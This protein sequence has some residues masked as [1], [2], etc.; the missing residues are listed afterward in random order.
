MSVATQRPFIEVF[1]RKDTNLEKIARRAVRQPD[2]IPEI[3]D[4]LSHDKTP[5]KYGCAKV[6]RIIAETRPDLLY[7]HFTTFARLLNHD[8]NIMKWE[9]IF[10]ISC[11]SVVD[12][13]NR[14]NRILKKYLKPITGP[15]LITAA[16]VIKGAARIAEAKPK[17]SDRI[18]GE[19]LKVEQ[20]HYKSPDCRNIAMGHAITSLDKM[21]NRVKKPAEIIRFVERQLQN[22]WPATR[23]KAE[24]FI[25]KHQLDLTNTS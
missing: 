20:A 15:M 2:Y 9:A 7:P 5:V 18:A 14:V 17:L 16:N 8:N 11:L 13:D 23:K 25:K 24:K 12:D 3:I 19:I 4:G 6:L 1:S 22:P 21:V 10:V